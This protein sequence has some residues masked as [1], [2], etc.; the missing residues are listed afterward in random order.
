MNQAV[1]LFFLPI[2]Q[3]LTSSKIEAFTLENDTSKVVFRP[4]HVGNIILIII[5]IYNMIKI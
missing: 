3:I 5:S 2:S 4:E 1:F